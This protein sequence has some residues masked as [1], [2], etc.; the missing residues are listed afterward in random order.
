MNP[1]RLDRIPPESDL[2]R[3][4]CTSYGSIVEAADEPG[5]DEA[6]LVG[7][8]DG[9]GPISEAEFCQDP[10]HVGLDGL[11]GHNQADG[12]LSVGQSTGD[13]YQYFALPGGEA[14]PRRPV[15]G[16]DDRLWAYSD[17]HSDG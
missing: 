11:L 5:Y 13:R 10:P 6:G 3:W 14:D 8:D 12:D 7:D 16:M 17:D 4:L 1:K 2:H 15:P 9:L